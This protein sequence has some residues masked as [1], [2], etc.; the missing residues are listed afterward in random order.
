MHCHIIIIIKKQLLYDKIIFQMKRAELNL[1]IM[2]RERKNWITKWT[3]H[4]VYINTI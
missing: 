2:D 4:N 3:P 1:I